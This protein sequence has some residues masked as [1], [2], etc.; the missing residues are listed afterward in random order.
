MNADLA[1][2]SQFL[3]GPRLI[4]KTTWTNESLTDARFRFNLLDR[5]LSRRLMEEHPM[6]T[7]DGIEVLPFNTFLSE[8]WSDKLITCS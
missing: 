6:K 1:R 4:G 8:L 7:D 2:K 3:F 5:N